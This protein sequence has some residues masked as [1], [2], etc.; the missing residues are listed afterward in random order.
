MNFSN[1]I[2]VISIRDTHN[3]SNDLIQLTSNEKYPD[4]T[5]DYFPLQIFDIKR[6]KSKG[7][8]FCVGLIGIKSRQHQKKWMKSLNQFSSETERLLLLK[9]YAHLEQ[10]KDSQTHAEF[11]ASRLLLMDE[12]FE[13]IKMPMSVIKAFLEHNDLTSKKKWRKNKKL[14]PETKSKAV[15]KT[16]NRA[17]SYLAMPTNK[18]KRVKKMSREQNTSKD[19]LKKKCDF[20]KEHLLMEMQEIQLNFKNCNDIP[21]EAF[22]KKLDFLSLRSRQLYSYQFID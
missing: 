7:Y 12:Y 20:V 8:K 13:V 10:M 19:Y 1:L 22:F 18:Q 2:S 4:Q 5:D 21:R 3:E 6:S 17:S 14:N 16:G 15:R 11:S 9:F